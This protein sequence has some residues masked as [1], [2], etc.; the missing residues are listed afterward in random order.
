MLSNLVE[1]IEKQYKQKLII[2]FK[3]KIEL[4]KEKHLVEEEHSWKIKT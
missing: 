2:I 1:D 4:K 3:F